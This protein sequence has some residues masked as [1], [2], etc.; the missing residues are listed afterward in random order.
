LRKL[1]PEAERINMIEIDQLRFRYPRS[2]F[3][4]DLPDLQIHDLEK[5]AIVGPSGCGKTTLLNL[6]SGITVPQSG[7]VLINEQP[8]SRL[9][10]SQRRDFRIANIGMVFQQF[11]LVDYLDVRN[12][13]L[14]PF[15]INSSLTLN[16]EVRDK[17]IKLAESMGLKE[18]LNRRSG[19]LSQGE[20]QRVAICRALITN[21]RIILAD[22]PTGNLDSKN[23]G[24]ILELI[25]EQA[26]IHA[27]TLVV[28]THDLG[29][30]HDFDRVIDF[31][32][33]RIDTADPEVRR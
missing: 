2:D 12:N 15:M 17:A 19:Q 30:L 16:H 5:V 18:K 26:A 22:E 21:P 33:F 25:F 8:I 24:L 10:D 13:I 1:R 11:E 6:I 29:I 20:Q 23:K 4:L 27:Q 31:E 14:L 9:A 3:L 32:Q 28:V 7:S